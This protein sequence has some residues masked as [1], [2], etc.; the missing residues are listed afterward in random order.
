MSNHMKISGHAN[1][2]VQVIAAAAANDR[3]CIHGQIDVKGEVAGLHGVCGV[4]VTIGLDGWRPEPLDWLNPE[5]IRAIQKSYCAL[6]EHGRLLSSCF[7]LRLLP[8][9]G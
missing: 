8:E 7:I 9:R 5:E 3:R 2:A 4:L 1:A 6:E